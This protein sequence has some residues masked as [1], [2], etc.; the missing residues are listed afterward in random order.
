MPKNQKQTK[1]RQIGKQKI[2]KKPL[3]NSK[4]KNTFWTIVVLVILLIFFIV[5][6]TRKVPDEGDYP[7]GYIPAQSESE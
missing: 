6:N 1:P 4:H 7:Q 2:E 5:N 3:I